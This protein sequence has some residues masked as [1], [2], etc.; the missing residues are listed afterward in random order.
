MS[1][2]KLEPRQSVVETGI[3]YDPDS[4]PLWREKIDW[5]LDTLGTRDPEL[6]RLRVRELKKAIWWLRRGRFVIPLN[7]DAT[8]MLK[9]Y[10]GRVLRWVDPTFRGG[11]WRKHRDRNS[12]TITY[13]KGI[14]LPPRGDM[15]PWKE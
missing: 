4:D 12:W 2:T 3:G 5:L 14:A 10:L 15:K 9:K 11:K 1:P 13:G 6:A 8:K 7:P